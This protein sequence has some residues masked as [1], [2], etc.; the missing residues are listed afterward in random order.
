MTDAITVEF[1]GIPRQRAGRAELTVL[2]DTL[3]D[4][5]QA[6]QASCPDLR[7][8]EETGLTPQYRISVDGR[9]FVTELGEK[10][11]PGERVLILSADAG[12]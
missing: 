6:V 4:L 1:Y 9:R 11:K 5:L 8:V 10:L 2:A 7:L 12:G 3:G